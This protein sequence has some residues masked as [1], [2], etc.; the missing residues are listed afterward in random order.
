MYARVLKRFSRQFLVARFCENM[1]DPHV[2]VGVFDLD[3]YLVKFS[4]ENLSVV[5]SRVS[6]CNHSTHVFDI[7]IAMFAL[8]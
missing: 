8:K 2:F 3:D 7:N 4:K 6:R 1:A 5:L